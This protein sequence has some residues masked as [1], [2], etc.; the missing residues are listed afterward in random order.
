MAVYSQALNSTQCNVESQLYLFLLFDSYSLM[1]W[2]ESQN[3]KKYE[4]KE[5][6]KHCGEEKGLLYGSGL[7]D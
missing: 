6:E 2:V 3:Y 4:N 5:L 1:T 7:A